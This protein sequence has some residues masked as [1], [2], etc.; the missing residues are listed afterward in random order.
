MESF[1]KL[2]NVY[3]IVVVAIIFIISVVSA[4][5][6]VID[7]GNSNIYSAEKTQKQYFCNNFYVTEL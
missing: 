7:R 3:T 1:D 2:F 4:C 6:I 5:L